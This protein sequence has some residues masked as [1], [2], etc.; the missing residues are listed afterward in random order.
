MDCFR[1]RQGFG[2]HVA[3][4]NDGK[5]R[6]LAARC[7]RALPE[8]SLPSSKRGR[9]EDRVRAAPAVSCAWVVGNAHTSIQVQREHPG[10]PCAMAL[11]LITSSP[12]RTALLPP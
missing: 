1:L 10:L 7:A 12:R 4:R 8:I 9:R 11:R 2:G 3:P 5:V 6:D